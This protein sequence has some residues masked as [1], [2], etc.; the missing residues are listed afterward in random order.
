M[1]TAKV[2]VVPPSGLMFTKAL[3]RVLIHEGGKVDHP[4]DP[5]GKTNRGITQRVY[6][7]WLGK[8]GQQPKDVY[9]ITDAEVEAI[10]KFQFWDAIKGDYLP[11]GVGYV[12]FDGAV[13]SGSKQSVKW[14]QR[15][16]SF[17]P[18]QVDGVL[19]TITLDAVNAVNDHDALIAKIIDRRE[20]FLRALKTF[21]T[22][23]KGW[24][25]RISDVEQTG[26]AWAV[27]SVG[28]N[29]SF[30][31]DGNAKADIEDAKTPPPKAPGDI[32]ATGGVVTGGAGELVRQAQ[33]QLAPYAS[34]AWVKPILVGIVIVGVVVAAGG[35]L[36]RWYANT[37]TNKLSDALDVKV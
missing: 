21:K 5:G 36:W 25:R 29:A 27:G 31:P 10:Y 32:T 3:K 33:E 8:S 30:I 7:A 17:T 26:Q 28:P 20:A 11:D 34:L 16:L 6:N 23:G 22:F 13:N 18:D 12:V 9:G 19:G 1:T 24:M 14:L 2:N 35:L 37:Q 4:K 15:A